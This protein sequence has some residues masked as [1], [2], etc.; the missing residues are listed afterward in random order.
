M[1]VNRR[2]EAVRPTKSLAMRLL[3]GAVLVASA[4]MGGYF[5]HQQ[6]AQ[7]KE[8]GAAAPAVAAKRVSVMVTAAAVRDF[9]RALV[10]QGN[11]QTKEFAMVSPRIPG[12]IEAIYVDEGDTVV[13]GRTKL[14]QTDAVNLERSVQIKQHATTVAQCSSREAAAGLDKVK[15]DLYKAELDFNRFKR[16]Y[17]Q[18]A[19][20]ADAFEQQ[21]SRYRQLQAAQ[22]LAEAQVDLATAVEN[23]SKA[24]L[25][26]AQKEL[27]DATAY[28]P[29][30]GKI[31][32][33]LGEPGEMGSPGRPLLRIDD[34]SV[35]EVVSSL[36]AQNYGEVTPGQTPMRVQ[37]SGID[38]GRQIITYKSPTINPKLRTFEVKC[39]LKD[40]PAAVAPGAMAQ[41]A[42]V[43]ETRRGLGVPSS[44]VQSRGG[45]TVVFVV[46]DGTAR[47]EAVTTGIEAEGWTEILQGQVKENEAVVTL[48]QNMLT[49]GAAVQVQQ[50]EK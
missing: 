25:A 37:V 15:V 5:I 1:T 33:R 46:R 27:A 17:D 42:V 48:G 24:E 41:I 21:Q 8:T 35:L 32:Q 22:K 47:Q 11:V 14:F 3:V 13:A 2:S 40:P 44:C 6:R 31:S 50:E 10:V 7:A 43:F 23:Q 19:V 34:T 9:E 26:I 49:E 20:T 12:M 38:L 45:G 28:A 39:L 36:P 29:I 18:N 4:T 30:S 16:L